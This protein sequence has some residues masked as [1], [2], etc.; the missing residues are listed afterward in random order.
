[1]KY[2]EQRIPQGHGMLRVRDYGGQGDAYVG[3]HGFPDNLQIFDEWAPLMA[4][5]GKRVITFDFLGFGGSDKT[6][7]MEYSFDQQLT[8]VKAVADGL[9][10]DKI[11][12]VGH[13]AGGSV[14]INFALKNPGRTAE[15]YLLNCFYGSTPTLK[16]PE[17]I[18]LFATGSLSGL[19]SAIL[20]DPGQMGW[21]L[22]FQGK[23]FKAHMPIALA[24]HFD[25][26]LMPIVAENFMQEQSAGPAFA[27]MTASAFPEVKRND[28]RL[29]AVQKLDIP[30]HLIWG[31]LDPYLNI[32]VAQ[33]LQSKLPHASL[34]TLPTGHWPQIDDPGA[35][36]NAMLSPK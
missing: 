7:T 16:L 25:E 10:L 20:A 24:K 4:E 31:E 15:V 23:Q 19:S 5:A 8:D 14:A 11:I 26:F 21:L 29:A 6:Q 22:D 13:D 36:A 34:V 18:E 32:G 2:Q 33:D 12:P 3:L 35:V 27:T 17:L 1:M 30:F 28:E 9:G